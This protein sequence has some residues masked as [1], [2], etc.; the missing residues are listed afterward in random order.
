MDNLL[1]LL[2]I[3]DFSQVSTRILAPDIFVFFIFLTL[4]DIRSCY[5]EHY[6][7]GIIWSKLSETSL[8]SESRI[9]VLSLKNQERFEIE[10]QVIE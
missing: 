9:A 7:Y 10:L 2:L 3:D 4:T 1:Q 5:P 8:Q 6:F